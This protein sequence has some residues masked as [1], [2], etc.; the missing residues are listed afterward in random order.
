MSFDKNCN[1]TPAD[2][3]NKDRAVYVM[4]PKMQF[5][6]FDYPQQSVR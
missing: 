6:A 5:T 4:I 1:I 3:T 2:F